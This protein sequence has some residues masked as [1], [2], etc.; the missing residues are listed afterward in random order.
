MNIQISNTL[1]NQ[2]TRN[3][4]FL[5]RSFFQADNRL[6][7]IANYVN[8]TYFNISTVDFSFYSAIELTKN[9]ESYSLQN[10]VVILKVDNQSE[11]LLEVF[12]IKDI[13][14]EYQDEVWVETFEWFFLTL[15]NEKGEINAVY[16]E[17]I[18]PI[19]HKVLHL[20][21]FKTSAFHV[22][23]QIE[24]NVM[25]NFKITSEASTGYYEGNVLMK[26][27]KVI[28]LYSETLIAEL[29]DVQLSQQLFI[30]EGDS[31]DSLLESLVDS[32]SREEIIWLALQALQKHKSGGI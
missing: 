17:D 18:L 16:S 5:P 13:P 30:E 22:G 28:D 2:E 31:E 19:I 3:D 7:Y 1:L 29:E 32:L 21:A 11:T 4:F 10:E 20:Y 26:S 23:K 6:F 14:T 9:N 12:S 25:D 15:R 27:W 24:I 8:Q